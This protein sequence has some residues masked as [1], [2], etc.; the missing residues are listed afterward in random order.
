MLKII[1][2]GNCK[3]TMKRKIFLVILDSNGHL[4]LLLFRTNSQISKA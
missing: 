1:E 2:W 3:Q 4:T